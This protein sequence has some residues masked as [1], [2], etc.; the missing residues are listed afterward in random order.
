MDRHQTLHHDTAGTHQF[1]E[2]RSALNGS[3]KYLTMPINKKDSDV[4]VLFNLIPQIKNLL[5]ENLKKCPKLRIAFALVG[6]FHKASETAN[7]NRDA[8]T[9]TWRSDSYTISVVELDLDST[10]YDA[11]RD[12]ENRLISMNLQGSGFLLEVCFFILLSY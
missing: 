6:Q 7:L 4:T 10:I 11:I 5:M 8:H 1:K 9:R 12:L 3:V 2:I